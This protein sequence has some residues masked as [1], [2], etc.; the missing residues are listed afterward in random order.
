[1]PCWEF[2]RKKDGNCLNHISHS[3]RTFLLSN[4]NVI[5]VNYYFNYLQGIY[6]TYGYLHLF[7]KAYFSHEIHLRKPNA[8]YI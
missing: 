3:Y 5:H 6:G 1:M 7:E 4:T 8:E 2:C